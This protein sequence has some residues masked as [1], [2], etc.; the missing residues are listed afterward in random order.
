MGQMKTPG[1]Y[2]VEKNAFPNSVVQVPTAVPVFIGHTE[3]AEN[4]AKSL[5][6]KPWKITSMVE[7]F[8]HFGGPPT[9]LFSITEKKAAPAPKGAKK[10]AAKEGDEAAAETPAEGAAPAKKFVLDDFTIAQS[11]N[12]YS[13]FYSMLLFFQNG[14]GPCYVTSIGD[15]NTD[16]EPA[17][18][19]KGIDLLVKEQEPT[20][21]VMPELVQLEF[22]DCI[23][24][25]QY[26][27]MHCAEVMQNRV[28]ILDIFNGD[29]D[30]QDP[31]AG[32]V[33]NS[34]REGI[35]INNLD[36]ASAYYPWINTSIV[37]DSSL[38]F[39]NIE[40]ASL[41][42]LKGY[43]TTELNQPVDDQ[44]AILDPQMDKEKIDKL[45]I[46][47]QQHV[48]LIAEVK[49]DYDL[50]DPASISK[51]K[52]ANK[53][54]SK[55]S[56]IF[57]SVL[58]EIKTQINLLP[59][60]AAMAGIFTMVDNSRGVWKAPANVSLNSVVSPSVN[61]THYDQEDLN[62][63]L[64]GKSINAIRSFVGEGVLV[65]GARTLD[66][67]SL[68]WRYINVRRT[69]IMLEQSI[70]FATK[71][72]VFEPNTANTWVTLKSMIRNF[73][74]GIWKQ[75]GLA[76]AVPEDAFSVHVGLGETMT[77]D[78]ILE[79]IMRITVLVA[80]SRPAEFI[81]ITFQQQMQKS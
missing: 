66:G 29:K 42:N 62:A 23:K 22:A 72:Y 60:A 30:R 37:D 75:G 17:K 21:I 46:V 55:V 2:I 38:S 65:W 76:G 54:I 56:T 43:M 26:S 80:I 6:E 11:G 31:D 44:I 27:L 40:P 39:L 78:D 73:L 24:I 64:S 59:P 52:S 33:I 8:N 53:S 67:N 3:K 74:T 36:F 20:M 51:F 57:N 79:G 19:Q 48:D 28:A 9:P 47:K 13:L 70:K 68:D 5:T 12:K 14:G 7:Y 58:K 69:M 50:S 25:Q 15:Y 61:I 16:F 32:D 1:V 35:G 45:N 10:A 77:P 63:P 4:G 81:E 18:F 34:F 49:T 41:E 71:A